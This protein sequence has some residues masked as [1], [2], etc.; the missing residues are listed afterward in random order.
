MADLQVLED[1][2][3]LLAKKYEQAN[4]RLNKLQLSNEAMS[5]ELAMSTAKLRVYDAFFSTNN[6]ILRPDVDASLSNAYD[7]INE[8]YR[9][10]DHDEEEEE[11]D[12]EDDYDER[13][14]EREFLEG[15]DGDDA[16]AM[17][18]I[19]A[20]FSLSSRL[21]MDEGKPNQRREYEEENDIGCGQKSTDNGSK[22]VMGEQESAWTEINRLRS[23]N[24]F[25][26]ADSGTAST[27]N[28][29]SRK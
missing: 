4:V 28:S 1:A 22:G 10:R 7:N 9:N 25:Q 14:D 5:R 12:D 6:N 26:L 27:S 24:S 21:R 2:N 29:S 13:D 20:Q 3:S 16:I 17:Y 19:L 8:Y 23:L 15:E 18:P 11:E